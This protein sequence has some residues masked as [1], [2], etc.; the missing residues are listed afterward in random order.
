MIESLPIETSSYE[1][2]KTIQIASTFLRVLSKI[3]D[4][5]L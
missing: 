2:R 5:C 4:G 1:R 3:M